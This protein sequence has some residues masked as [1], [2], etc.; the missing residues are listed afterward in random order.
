[1]VVEFKRPAD[2][3]LLLRLNLEEKIVK[4]T[5]G[6]LEPATKRSVLVITFYKAHTS[7]D[8]DCR[9]KILCCSCVLLEFCFVSVIDSNILLCL[10]VI[11]SE[12]PE[13]ISCSTPCLVLLFLHGPSKV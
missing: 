5:A 10:L 11:N 2:H 1:M 7:N 3:A 13:C 4:G 12:P 8:L 6:V 9:M